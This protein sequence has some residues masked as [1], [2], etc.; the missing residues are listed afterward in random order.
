MGGAK[1]LLL[2][3]AEAVLLL[4]DELWAVLCSASGVN[5]LGFPLGVLAVGIGAD[6][7]FS[8]GFFSVA[9]AAVWKAL[10]CPCSAGFEGLGAA[11]PGSKQSKPSSNLTGTNPVTASPAG[12]IQGFG[13]L[14][15]V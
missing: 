10:G 4:W 5:C 12:R 15:R 3:L 8:G 13:K 6:L 9:A 2:L 14:L 7:V 11:G 1:L